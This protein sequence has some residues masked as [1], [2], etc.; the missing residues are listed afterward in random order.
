MRKKN[1][2]QAADR[3]LALLRQGP[4]LVRRAHQA[5]LQRGEFIDDFEFVSPGGTAVSVG[6]SVPTTTAKVNSLEGDD[7]RR[8]AC[9]L[10]ARRQGVIARRWTGSSS[11]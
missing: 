1:A 8:A 6:S 4:G 7:R 10:H 9:G 3:P 2:V 5:E 11:S